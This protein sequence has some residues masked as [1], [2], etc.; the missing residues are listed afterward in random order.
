MPAGP[1]IVVYCDTISP[2]EL[3]CYG[4][5]IARTPS[6]DQLA[7]DGLV[8]HEHYRTLSADQ[9]VNVEE[10]IRNLGAAVI[11][12]S[13]GKDSGEQLANLL[14]S[15]ALCVW[16][17]VTTTNNAEAN[18]AQLENISAAL[19]EAD[20]PLHGFFTAREGRMLPTDEDD[21]APFYKAISESITIPNWLPLVL[22]GSAADRIN[23]SGHYTK[24]TDDCN[25]WE[26]CEDALK[27]N[28]TTSWTFPEA[29]SEALLLR[30]DSA[31]GLRTAD[32]LLVVSNDEDFHTT[33]EVPR[34]ASY[35]VKPEDRFDVNDV[36]TTVPELAQERWQTL[37]RRQ[38]PA[39]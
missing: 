28:A 2:M 17:N 34:T 18:R 9:I 39:S 33:D 24:L 27:A 38:L 37:C 8:C 1:L 30:T 23:H 31:V 26:A 16:I 6:F 21:L 19:L 13:E 35:F 14:Q 3:S 29:P 11:E 32:D 5:R 36:V 25:L 12:W 15:E 7:A 4:S 10:Q 20:V 22:F